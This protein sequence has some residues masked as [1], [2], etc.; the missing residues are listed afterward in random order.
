MLGLFV[1]DERL[2][3]S[4]PNLDR[5]WKSYTLKEQSMIL[6][7]WEKERAKIPDKIKELEKIVTY[8]TKEL[9]VENN[10]DKMEQLNNEIMTFASM[11]NDLNILFRIEPTLTVD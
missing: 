7:S 9:L 6:S 5:D 3:I 4:I 8:K 2:G 10:G 1:K 11:I